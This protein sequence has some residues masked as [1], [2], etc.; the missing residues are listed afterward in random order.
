MKKSIEGQANPFGFLNS[1]RGFSVSDLSDEE[2]AKVA[3]EIKIR[4]GKD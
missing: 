1:S 4:L 2:L 3:E